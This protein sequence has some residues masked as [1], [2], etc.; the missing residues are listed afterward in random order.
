[1]DERAKVEAEIAR[2]IAELAEVKKQSDAYKLA[3]NGTF[4]K[5][6]SKWSIF[7]APTEMIQVTI[8]GQLA[9]LMLIEMLELSGIS[10][11]S[12]N[13]DGIITRCPRNM[14]WLRDDIISW[15]E[16]VTGFSMEHAEYSAVYSRDVN[17]YIAIKPDGE[18]K[19]KGEFSPPEPGASGWPNPTGQICVDAIV[20]HLTNGTPLADTIHACTDVRRFVHV[21]AVKGGG[22]WRGEPLGKVVRWYYSNSGE[23]D[24][25]TYLSNGNKVATSDG[26]RPM[27]ELTDRIP[28]DLD[29]ARYVSDAE[30][31]RSLFQN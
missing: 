19:L 27:M 4:G 10:V 29:Y 17:S 18:V 24:C 6:G 30:N 2:V 15:W 11:V 23:A 8:T 12:A 28:S 26:C 31:Y 21:R 13:T 1:M 7:Y 22:V 5:L 16:S 20:A 3:G 9:L 14:T 25:I